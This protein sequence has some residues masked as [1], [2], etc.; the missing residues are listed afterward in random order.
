MY[1]EAAAHFG[2]TPEVRAALRVIFDSYAANPN[3]FIVPDDAVSAYRDLA[4]AIG[5]SA[6]G[7]PE[8]PPDEEGAPLD[9][10]QAVTANRI[11]EAGAQFG[12]FGN[13]S[14]GILGGLRQL[15]F[16]TMKKRARSIG[17][18]GMHTFVSS[19]L[20][21]S[22]ARVHLMGHSFGCVVMSSILGGPGGNGKLPR[23]VSSCVLVQGAVSL[24]SWGDKVKDRD[25]PGYFRNILQNKAI[26]GP[27]VT[28]RSVHD[29]AVGLAYPAAVA[30][31][32]QAAFD[33]NSL[34]LFGGIGS[35]GLQGTSVAAD[36][37]MLPA[38]GVY[39]FQPGKI[40]NLECSP[41]IAGH[42]A[43]DGPEVAHMIWQAA[44]QAPKG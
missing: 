30:L 27:I 33:P 43:I 7:G 13:I 41:F 32:G 34:P 21:N 8:A 40:C 42:S 44:R 38:T 20:A 37:A 23:P 1:E 36:Q 26:A 11:A 2:N 15:S 14:K 28:T 18:G 22:T 9:P 6:G 12:I 24:W 39:S 25:T 19:L 29:K 17:E 3:R 31:V 35:F 4:R 16:W 5:F 10:Q